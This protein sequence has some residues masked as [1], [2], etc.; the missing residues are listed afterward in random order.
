MLNNKY[1]KTM[2]YYFMLRTFILKGKQ[3]IPKKVK[4]MVAME[5]I[6]LTNIL[7]PKADVA[8]TTNWLS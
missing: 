3:I 5:R 6:V 2:N 4:S 7:V 8:L 1:W